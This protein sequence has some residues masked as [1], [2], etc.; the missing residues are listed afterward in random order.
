MSISVMRSFSTVE[1]AAKAHDC[2][3]VLLV[4]Y[5]SHDNSCSAVMIGMARSPY[6][7]DLA[8][9]IYSRLVGYHYWNLASGHDLY[10][11]DVMRL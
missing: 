10:L 3:L 6:L 9:C 8:A 1:I 5:I 2:W 11:K 4:E 7:Y